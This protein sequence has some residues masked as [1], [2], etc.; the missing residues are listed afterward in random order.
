MFHSTFISFT[1]HLLGSYT[2]LMWIK[3]AFNL[4]KLVDDFIQMLADMS[5][6]MDHSIIHHYRMKAVTYIDPSHSDTEALLHKLS[7]TR[8]ADLM[9]TLDALEKLSIP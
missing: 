2:V 3:N 4:K 6:K 1:S 7:D 8:P 9:R 5:T